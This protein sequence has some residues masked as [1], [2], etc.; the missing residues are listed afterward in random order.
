[1]LELLAPA[2]SREAV[3]AAV[4]NGAGAVYLGLGE[5]NARRSAANFDR[6]SLAETVD[7]CHLR[8]VKVYVTLNTLLSDRELPRAAEEVDFISRVGVDAVLVQDLGVLDLARRTAPDLPIHASTQMSI[9][10]LDGVK[11]AADLGCTRA[12]LARELPGEEIAYICRHSPIEIETFVHGAQCMCY[13]GQCYFSSVVGGRSGNRG[14][15]AQPC[16]LNYGWGE[17]ADRPLLSLKD[18][19]LADHLGELEE[20]GVACVKI[21]GRMKRP[22][23]VAVVTGIYARLIRERRGP[24]RDERRDLERAFSRDGF[25][26]GYFADRTGQ[27]MF[28]ARGDARAPE[29]LFAAARAEY[30]KE[31]PL[32]SVSGV[33]TLRPGARTAF[34]LDDGA[35]AVTAAG[36]VPEAARSRDLTA[37]EASQRMGKLG[38]TPF[39]LTRLQAEVAPGLRLSAAAL[40][41]LRRDAAERLSAARTARPDR[42]RG[43]ADPVAGEKAFPGEMGYTVSVQSARQVTPELIER[44]PKVLF[45]PVEAARAL[46]DE[47]VRLARAQGTE[48]SVMLPRILWDREKPPVERA[49]HELAARGFSSALVPNLGGIDP[50]LRAG[51]ALRGDF[52]LNVYNARTA[53]ALGEMGFLSVTA[54][55][56]QRLA[57]IRDSVK[58]LPTEILAYGR[59]PLMV[60][61]N[62]IVKNRDGGCRHGCESAPLLRDRMGARFPVTRADGCRSEI[63]NALP[64]FLAD[65]PGDLTR[66]GAWAA[67]LRFTTESPEVCVRVFD[68]YLGQDAY[69]PAQYTRGLYYRDVE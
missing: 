9:L 65:K 54:S 25:S 69:Q 28:G 6:E 7:Y 21:E 46:S 29:E 17:K 16:R 32:V 53:R 50:A 52:G 3:T 11:R 60:T 13:S 1:M 38:G 40:N 57:R 31:H 19:C 24:T 41:A 26:D 61:E 68:R 42:R 58:P 67:R 35:H 18:M 39:S 15:C 55:F 23:Y 62:C 43:T 2:G 33:L 10:D 64:L 20:M 4:Q 44:G 5:F 8:G 56:E 47:L 22:E 27:A 37:E 59:L 51:L 36:P 66:S 14:M 49:L 12:V 48:L 34:T 30:G 45:L 63:Q